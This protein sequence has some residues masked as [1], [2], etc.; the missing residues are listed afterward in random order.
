[1][2]SCSF[3]GQYRLTTSFANVSIPIFHR[4]I[5]TYLNGSSAIPLR[6]VFQRQKEAAKPPSTPPVVRKQK[7]P[8]KLPSTPPVASSSRP[9][10]AKAE[11]NQVRMNP[12]IHNPQCNLSS[13]QPIMPIPSIPEHSVQ[14]PGFMT[15]HRPSAISSDLKYASTLTDDELFWVV[16]QGAHPGV[17][18]GK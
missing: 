4:E 6:P 7:E 11:P 16:V 13:V 9:T 5:I 10:N 3:H 17:Y 12:S 8:V 18:H 14:M 15:P 1:M 2:G